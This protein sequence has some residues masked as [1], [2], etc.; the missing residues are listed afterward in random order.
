MR[1]PVQLN[2]RS[3]FET[4]D[5]RPRALRS[6]HLQVDRLA[7]LKAFA[8]DL[9]LH[10]RWL[11]GD[12]EGFGFS[13]SVALTIAEDE[14]DRVSSVLHVGRREKARLPDVFGAEIAQRLHQSKR[15]QRDHRDDGLI[16]LDAEDRV[17]RT[18]HA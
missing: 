7:S 1:I 17:A 14:S 4:G 11:A 10:D 15:K 8:V 13:I 12:D 5:Q 16:C 2:W 9:H 18:N 6:I 3:T